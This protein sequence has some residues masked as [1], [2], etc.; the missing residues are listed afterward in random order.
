MT[1]TG[2]NHQP[3]PDD[4]IRCV[5]CGGATIP[6][7]NCRGVWVTTRPVGGGPGRTSWVPYRTDLNSKE[8]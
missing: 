2:I 1:R 3:S 4:P 8:E 7:D 6:Y 5:D